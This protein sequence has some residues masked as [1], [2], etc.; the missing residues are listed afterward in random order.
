MLV[1]HT[2]DMKPSLIVRVAKMKGS[3]LLFELSRCNFNGC[4][5][6]RILNT[7]A[8]I[9]LYFGKVNAVLNI[10]MNIFVGSKP[11]NTLSWWGREWGSVE[12]TLNNHLMGFD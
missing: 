8:G 11:K 9:Q 6:H 3:R 10:I 7:E 5:K 12:D 2:R 4:V 1:F